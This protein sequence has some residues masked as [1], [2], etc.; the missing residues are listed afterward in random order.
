[1]RWISLRRRD[2]LEPER[3]SPPNLT[4]AALR[5]APCSARRLLGASQFERSHPRQPRGSRVATRLLGGRTI[6]L[7]SP[8]P[9][10]ASTA[11]A[12]ASTSL[13]RGGA[14]A[15]D[16]TTPGEALAPDV[17][18]GR[19]HERPQAPPRV[20]LAS[21]H[22]AAQREPRSSQSVSAAVPHHCSD[23][24]TRR[25]AVRRVSAPSERHASVV[26]PPRPRRNVRL[27]GDSNGG[28]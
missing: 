6:R 20:L 9:P 7:A 8:L 23:G 4:S 18:C 19:G 11:V 21:S 28:S 5:P 25:T 3:E 16:G 24:L 27:A 1:M 13:A 17:S 22:C 12:P 10:L 15:P 2:A 14:A 26:Q